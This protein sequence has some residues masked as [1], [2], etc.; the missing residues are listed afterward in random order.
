MFGREKKVGYILLSILLLWLFFGNAFTGETGTAAEL[1]P[2]A[3]AVFPHAPEN[4]ANTITVQTLPAGQKAPEAKPAVQGA[5][6]NE[7]IE[8]RTE[9]GEFKITAYCPCEI[10]NGRWTGQPA[11]NGEEM[12][13]GL[14][15]AVDPDVI[16]L[17]SYVYIEGVGVRKA[18]DTG[19]AI[20]GDKIDLFFSTHGETQEWGVRYLKVYW[21]Y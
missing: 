12:E 19:S 4:R 8:Q 11:K 16:P 2:A 6:E 3:D 7:Y 14:T 1:S 21:L 9:I 17:G 15:I 10:C 5:A 20:R 13:A 18:Q